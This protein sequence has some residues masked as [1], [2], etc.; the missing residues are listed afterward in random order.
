MNLDLIVGR[1]TLD[2][3][4]FATSLL[5]DLLGMGSYLGY[6]GGP[7]G[8]VTEASDGIFA[9]IQAAYIAL[10]Y[11]RLDSIPFAVAGGLEEIL[12]GTDIVPTC[13]LYHI[14]VMRKKYGTEQPALPD[15]T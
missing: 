15:K 10:A 13:I 4:R 14:Y 11:Q 12:P 2:K 6:L 3:V 5:V 7:A 9:P 8:A 1:T